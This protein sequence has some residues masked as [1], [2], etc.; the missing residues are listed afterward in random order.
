MNTIRQKR[1][2]PAWLWCGLL[3]GLAGVA[4]GTFLDLRLDQ[5]LY[6]PDAQWAK[7]MAAVVP[8]PAFWGLGAAGFLTIDVMKDSKLS[9]L[10]WILGFGMLAYGPI[11]MAESFVDEMAMS[12]LV[13]WAIGFLIAEVPAWLYSYFM[14]NASRK[15]KITCIW[16]LLIV[17]VGSMG[18]VQVV[19][20]VWMRPRYIAMMS[21]GAIPFHPWYQMGRDTAKE[22]ATLYESNHDLFRSFPSGHSQSVTCLFLWALIPV[23]THKGSVNA[24]MAIA[25]IVSWFGMFSRLVMGAHFL[26]DVSAG[27]LVT[28]ILFTICCFAFGLTKGDPSRKSSYDDEFDVEDDD[29]DYED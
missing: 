8:A 7:F 27:Y 9:V 18:I 1:I 29:E 24:T 4:A 13:A 22:F 11:Y 20:R 10:G 12:W 2:S 19:K 15:D 16:I 3:L 26:S 14:R 28:F 17:C 6:H 23:F 25:M 21:E 5:I